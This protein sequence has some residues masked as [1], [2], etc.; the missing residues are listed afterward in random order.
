M[1]DRFLLLFALPLLPVLWLPLIIGF[2]CYRN[3]QDA[4]GPELHQGG[5]RSSLFDCGEASFGLRAGSMLCPALIT[6]GRAR[7]RA[8]SAAL[9]SPDV[10]TLSFPPASLLLQ[11][12]SPQAREY[13]D[14]VLVP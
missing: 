11:F 2:S 12:P 5:A 4:A 6:P 1:L 8:G 13:A 7:M 3:A 9:A 14:P 10:C